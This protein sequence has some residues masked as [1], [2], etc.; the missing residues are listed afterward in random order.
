V[1]YSL[2]GAS[3]ISC[4]IEAIL[5]KVAA[6]GLLTKHI[7][8]TIESMFP[9]LKHL[10][11][12]YGCNVCGEGG[13][14]ETLTLDCPLF[15]YGR[16]VIDNWKVITV[17]P[18]SIAPV[19]LLH[20]EAFHVEPKAIP[21]GNDGSNGLVISVPSGFSQSQGRGEGRSL[22]S[23]IDTKAPLDRPLTSGVR[24]TTAIHA[25]R[26]TVSSREEFATIVAHVEAQPST[27]SL[28]TANVLSAQVT[29]RMLKEA[30]DAIGGEMKRLQVQWDDSLFV[31]LY[32]PSMQHFSEANAA[33]LEIIPPINP[34]ARACVQLDSL[35]GAPDLLIVEILYRRCVA[36]IDVS[37]RKVLHVQSISKWAPSCI[38]P[39][40]QAVMHNK[41]VHLAGQIP[42]IPETMQVLA[43]SC[44]AASQ[45][46]AV[47][48]QLQLVLR[49]CTSVAIAMQTDFVKYLLWGTLYF[50][51][52]AYESKSALTEAMTSLQSYLDQHGRADDRETDDEGK[53]DIQMDSYLLP[54]SGVKPRYWEPLVL[55]VALPS[56]PRGVDVE[57]QPVIASL[58]HMKNRTITKVNSDYDAKPDIEEEED[59]GQ[60]EW[61]VP[62]DTQLATESVQLEDEASHTSVQMLYYPGTEAFFRAHAL[63]R[64]PSG[65][66]QVSAAT[67]ARAVQFLDEEA[68]SKMNQSE[69]G[70]WGLE[71]CQRSA[72]GVPNIKIYISLH[73]VCC[74]GVDDFR[75]SLPTWLQGLATIIPVIGIGNLNGVEGDLGIEYFLS[76]LDSH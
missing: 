67:V 47:T 58:S 11:S 54:P 37:Q 46:D 35:P 26:Q 74:V 9:H 30:L 38:G 39:Y 52:K 14:Y 27:E 5:V 4:P 64:L 69:C 72:C 6:A 29:A 24:L 2:F 62:G 50:S 68:Q 70:N 33:Y 61:T 66:D 32:L 40:S 31:H 44:D 76:T 1:N 8:S 63:I 55:W 56:L 20:P 73:K 36:Q 28:D 22:D 53:R 34:P 18:D 49:H 45:V 65:D 21:H 60:C 48:A 59:E 10:R 23:Y 19:A 42:L 57:L 7:G 51:R 12:M 71:S 43:A 3:Q 15:K 13:E 41:F 17:S 25:T 75:R 16:I